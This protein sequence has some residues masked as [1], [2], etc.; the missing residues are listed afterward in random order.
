[1]NEKKASTFRVIVAKENLPQNSHIVRALVSSETLTALKQI[2]DKSH[3][4]IQQLT[5]RMIQYAIDNLE[6]VE[7]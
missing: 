5:A 2:S 4:S 7:V 3:I 6:Y 1:M